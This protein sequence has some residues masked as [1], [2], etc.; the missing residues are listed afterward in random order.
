MTTNKVDCILSSYCKKDEDGKYSESDTKWA[1][2][3]ATERMGLK[4]MGTILRPRCRYT[5]Q[6]MINITNVRFERPQFN[7][8]SVLI[9]SGIGLKWQR[10]WV[11]LD[12]KQYSDDTFIVSTVRYDPRCKP[13]KPFGVVHPRED[14]MNDQI[15]I[16]GDALLKPHLPRFLFGMIY[17]F[18][19]GYYSCHYCPC[20]RRSKCMNWFSY[21]QHLKE[22]LFLQI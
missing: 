21:Q 13:R 22:C 5:W 14:W 2:A 11:T 15:M 1:V 18:V 8:N 4:A 19:T 17:E 6:A 12:K 16:H 7:G 20:S 3:V 9:V 10:Q